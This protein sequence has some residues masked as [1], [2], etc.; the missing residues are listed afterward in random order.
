MKKD[1]VVALK[2]VC[3]K[4]PLFDN[5]SERFWY[6]F[7]LLR[8]LR[9]KK[10]LTVSYKDALKN[11]DLTIRKGEKVGIIG[12]NGSGKTTLLNL[13][14][15]YS[16]A[17]TGDVSVNGSVQALMQTGLGFH[18]ELSGADNVRNALQLNGLSKSQ[19]LK[20]FEDVV[21]FVELGEFL[22]YPFKTYS[23]GMRARLEFATATAIYPDILA[24]DEV[25]GAG[26][27]YFAKKCAERMRNLVSN[28]TLLLVT[29]SM[30]Q[31]YDFCDRV[32]WI[33]SGVVVDDG[34]P[35]HVIK[36]YEEY[37]AQEESKIQASIKASDSNSALLVES[38]LPSPE[39][40]ASAS[41]KLLN[42]LQVGENLNISDVEFAPDGRRVHFL[43][44]GDPLGINVNVALRGDQ[45][46]Y[47]AVVFAFSENGS[48]LWRAQGCS[49]ELVPD[50]A[51]RASLTLSAD[52]FIGG[53]GNYYLT[54]GI[55]ECLEGVGKD[56]QFVDVLHAALY[57]KVMETNY[58]DPPFFHCPGIWKA[59]GKSEAGRK[60]RVSAWV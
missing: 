43:E 27:G 52:Q 3:K 39:A 12:S 58:S 34:E 22:Q 18:E 14:V 11:V 55:E 2:G 42:G 38:E 50:S 53:V 10:N 29:H 46:S 5:K 7:P 19:R 30:G 4:F 44:T 33:N 49:L 59:N 48:Y 15:G 17:S 21:D 13:I 40:A 20:A 57:L 32:I 28:T 6:H 35:E 45:G 31:I 36:A 1:I 25:L 8:R 56:A 37:M 60:S 41:K 16:T 54:V 51:G 26:D 24:I 47:R 9:S 23:L